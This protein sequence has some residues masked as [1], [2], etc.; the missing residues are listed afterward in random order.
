MSLSFDWQFSKLKN[1]QI[2]LLSSQGYGVR[3]SF[4]FLT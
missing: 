1:E 2:V 3:S 4:R